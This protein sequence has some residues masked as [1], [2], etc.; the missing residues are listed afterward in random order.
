MSAQ[1]FVIAIGRFAIAATVMLI[2]AHGILRYRFP[3]NVE[4]RVLFIYGLLNVGVYLGLYVIALQQ[5]SAG[6]AAL[7]VA[8]NPLLITTISAVW[9]KR[10]ISKK[11]IIAL[12]ICFIGV[13]V[14]S[15]PLI[16][17]GLTT[18]EG[19]L[20]LLASMVSYSIGAV[21]FSKTAW[22]NLNML[23]INGWQ[24]LF[25]GLFVL[26]FC[27]YFYN[28][29]DNLLDARFWLSTSWLAVPVS[30]IAVLL[31]QYL[32]RKDPLEA[33]FW[34]FLCPIAGFTI[35]TVLLG[36]PVTSFTLIGVLLVIVGLFIVQRR[37]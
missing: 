31:W 29:T 19:L 5:V 35:A 20:L 33:S 2:L 4:W 13:T 37:T 11:I 27:I 9:L 22:G 12:S 26:P 3:K 18:I 21:Y 16:E 17:G 8:T 10:P 24:T 15:A 34:L 23:V 32:L 6:L 14:V 25:G 1:P 28:A 7:L 30:I 36:E